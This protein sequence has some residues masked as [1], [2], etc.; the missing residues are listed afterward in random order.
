MKVTV[1]PKDEF[2]ELISDIN[3]FKGLDE[4]T[5]KII[6]ILYAEPKEISL[7]EISKRTGYSLSSISTSMKM[8]EGPGFAKRI[9]KPG[10]RK[11]Y[12]YVQKDLI[13]LFID[14]MKKSERII[15][16]AKRRVPSIV[17]GY[18]SRKTKSAQEELKIVRDYYK[19]VQILEST[20]N[21]FIEKL[22]ECRK[23]L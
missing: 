13:G 1:S 14:A 7:E 20:M 5:S 6:A 21:V 16:M 3:R 15:G 11:V 17:E 4:L 23:K 18:K 10:S 8:L 2:I 22:R 12:F 19:Q 9:K